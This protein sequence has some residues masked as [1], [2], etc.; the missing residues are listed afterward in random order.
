MVNL[1]CFTG[2]YI[3]KCKFQYDFFALDTMKDRGFFGCSKVAVKVKFSTF[4]NASRTQSTMEPLA[5][6]ENGFKI[7][8]GLLGNILS[9]D[10]AKVGHFTLLIYD[11]Y[12]IFLGSTCWRCS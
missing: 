3:L 9:K 10:N 8:K 12:C 4:K 6:A 1:T 11:L 5:S 2:V 7:A